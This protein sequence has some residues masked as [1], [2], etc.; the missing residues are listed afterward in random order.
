MLSLLKV[1]I[2][3]LIL[4]FQNNASGEDFCHPKC[5]VKCLPS[6]GCCNYK[7][8]AETYEAFKRNEIKLR[9]LGR[10]IIEQDLTVGFTC[11]SYCKKRCLPSCKFSCC[12]ISRDDVIHP[13][14]KTPGNKIIIENEEF[15]LNKLL[16]AIENTQQEYLKLKVFIKKLNATIEQ[17]EN[18]PSAVSDF[19][20]SNKMPDLSSFTEKGNPLNTPKN[21]HDKNILNVAMETPLLPVVNKIEIADTKHFDKQKFQN[22]QKVLEIKKEKERLQQIKNQ[23]KAKKFED[24]KIETIKTLKEKIEAEVQKRKLLRQRKQMEEIQKRKVEKEKKKHHEELV[25][26]LKALTDAKLKLKSEFLKTTEETEV[27]G[28]NQPLLLKDI[29]DNQPLILKDIGDKTEKDENKEIKHLDNIKSLSQNFG[30]DLS[31]EGNVGENN[32]PD[33][34]NSDVS[35]SKYNGDVFEKLNNKVSTEEKIDETEKYL[36]HLESETLS[37]NKHN[38]SNLKEILENIEAGH[39]SVILEVIDGSGTEL[40]EIRVKKKK[41]RKKNKHVKSKHKNKNIKKRKRKMKHIENKMEWSNQNNSISETTTNQILAGSQTVAIGKQISAGSESTTEINQVCSPTCVN[42]CSPQCNFDCCNPVNNSILLT[43]GVQSQQ[44][45][46]NQTTI[47]NPGMSTYYHEQNTS[48]SFYSPSPSQISSPS[49]YQQPMVLPGISFVNSTAPSQSYISL[50]LNNTNNVANR[51]T[52]TN[53]NPATI[54]YTANQD[55]ETK[56]TTKTTAKKLKHHGNKSTHKKDDTKEQI[57]TLISL[58]QSTVQQFD[59]HNNTGETYDG[60]CSAECKSQCL[61]FCH[62]DCC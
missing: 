25:K 55:V 44:Q 46:A 21:K 34:R 37:K 22:K 50:P 12:G 29:G 10:M 26:K 35:T 5:Y 4:N 45:W 17:E 62:F 3:F 6:C 58:L 40:S 31:A 61:P 9:N 41:K 11:N 53:E 1:F 2:V 57:Q 43:N 60:G 14:D 54:S 30:D 20:E 33:D 15:N 19:S 27:S 32:F 23:R 13:I 7:A 42:E 51:Y 16:K 39:N 47:Y 24:V 18:L 59:K 36:K 49:Y 48:Q 56:A 28:D 52:N 8:P 38:K